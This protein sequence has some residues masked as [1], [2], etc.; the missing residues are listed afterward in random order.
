MAKKRK[1]EDNFDPNDSDFDAGG[2]LD[3]TAD[4][5]D[6]V[7][8]DFID[9]ADF[10][11]ESSVPSDPGEAVILSEIPED[12]GLEDNDEPTPAVEE[13]PEPAPT[14]KGKGIDFSDP[15]SGKEKLDFRQTLDPRS[16]DEYEASQWGDVLGAVISSELAGK[17]LPSD[18]GDQLDKT[19]LS[20]IPDMDSRDQL[21]DGGMSSAFNSS[22]T[23]SSSGVD[24]RASTPSLDGLLNVQTRPVV[25]EIPGLGDVTAGSRLQTLIA[26]RPKG[27]SWDFESPFPILANRVRTDGMV[28][29]H[30]TNLEGPILV[31]VPT[32]GTTDFVK[33]T[34]SESTDL[35]IGY[36]QLTLKSKGTVD[37]AEAH[38]SRLQEKLQAF[39]TATAAEAADPDY[40]IVRELAQGGM[41]VVYLAKQTA[42]SREIA[43]K[44]L[45]PIDPKRKLP[46]D[47]KGKTRRRTTVNKQ[48]QE[49]FLSEA[50]VTANLVHPN[51]VPVHDLGR[52][53]TGDPFYTMKVVEGLPWSKRLEHMTREENIEV[54]LKVCDAMA[55]AHSKGVINR[56]LKPDNVMLG[57]FGEVV[58]LDWG[59]AVHA[60]DV[61]SG[62]PAAG[63]VTTVGAGT[64]LY[65]AP[66][67]ITGPITKIGRH[68]DIYLL[69]GILYEIVTGHP[70]HAPGNSRRAM[71]RSIRN[72]MIR[73]TTVKSELVDIA[74]HAMST[75]PE[76]RFES[77]QAFQEAIR[78]FE[79]HEE[80]LNLSTRARELTEQAKAGEGN[81]EDYQN[82]VALYGESLRTWPGNTQAEE[83]LRATRLEFA[84]VARERGDYDLGLQVARDEQDKEFKTVRAKM[85]KGKKKRSRTKYITA[86]L[87]ASL[88]LGGLGAA[89]TFRSQYNEIVTVRG[90][91]EKI[92]ADAEKIEA[93]AKDTLAEAVEK[94]KEADQKLSDANTA[95]S[96]AET[97]RTEATKTL[98]KAAAKDR[99]ADRKL[100]DANTANSEAETNRTEAK[101][102]RATARREVVESRITVI[103][104]SIE[105]GD[106]DSAI[107][108]I[109]ELLASEEFD[110]LDEQLRKN[111]AKS[112]VA[113]RKQLRDS[114][115]EIQQGIGAA[116]IGT[117]GI[118]AFA[119][120]SELSVRGNKVPEVIDT[121]QIALSP[122]STT[123]AAV[124]RNAITIY[125]PAKNQR[126]QLPAQN[127]AALSFIGPNGLVLGSTTGEIQIRDLNSGEVK[128]ST[129]VAAVKDIVYL[130][131]RQMLLVASSRGGQSIECSAFRIENG[132][133]TITRHSQLNTRNVL[134][135]PIARIVVSPDEKYLAVANSRTG[136][137]VVLTATGSRD[138]FPYRLANNN[139]RFRAHSGPIRD[140]AFSKDSRQLIT[141]SV[142][143]TV[144]VWQRRPTGFERRATLLGHG[145]PIEA[146]GF[147]GSPDKA[148]SIGRD[149]YI[150]RWDIDGE[151]KRRKQLLKVSAAKRTGLRYL[152]TVFGSGSGKV[153]P[154][155]VLQQPTGDSAHQGT[156]VRT[157]K[158]S[159]TRAIT[160]GDNR[161]ATLWDAASGKSLMRPDEEDMPGVRDFEEGHEFNI[162]GLKFFRSNGDLR[163]LTSGFDATV[164]VW[165]ADQDGGIGYQLA[166]LDR[167][168]MQNAATVS[169]DGELIITSG[170][171]YEEQRKQ[172]GDGIPIV[173]AQLWQA[174]DLLAGKREPESI[175]LS[176]RFHRRR[177]TSVAI[178]QDK[179]LAATGALDGGVAI[180]DIANPESARMV[181][182]KSCHGKSPVTGMQFLKNR[183]L[184]TA[185]ADGRVVQWSLG[186]GSIATDQVI[187]KERAQINSMQ[188]TP[189]EE[190]VLFISAR[191]EKKGGQR[192][193]KTREV[194]T[195]Q[196]L[197]TRLHIASLKGS[198]EAGKVNGNGL[199]VGDFARLP[200]NK[201]DF[202][203]ISAAW[204]PGSGSVVAVVTG[205]REKDRPNDRVVLFVNT[206]TGKVLKGLAESE[207]PPVAIA[208]PSDTDGTN[209]MATFDGVNA[210]LWKLQYEGL[211][212]K[213]SDLKRGQI[214]AVFSPH[215]QVFAA[216]LSGDDKYLVTASDAIRVFDSKNQLSLYKS[217]PADNGQI[218]SIAFAPSKEPIYRLLSARR[219]GVVKVWDWE[220][221]QGPDDE[222][223][224]TQQ[225]RLETGNRESSGFQAANPTR[226]AVW[227]PKGNQIGT[228]ILEPK[229]WTKNNNNKWVSKSAVTE[230]GATLLCCAFSAD[231]KWF[232]AGGTDADE[233]SVGWVWNVDRIKNDEGDPHCRISGHRL[234]GITAISFVAK[235][236]NENTPYIATGG[237]DGAVLMWDWWEKRT[238]PDGE[239]HTAFESFRFLTRKDKVTD[240]NERF[241]EAHSATV[242]CIDASVPGKIATSSEDGTAILWS[243]PLAPASDTQSLSL[244]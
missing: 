44:T 2:T 26:L 118:V 141:G 137:L 16:M 127:V 61:R 207:A 74:K 35:G 45:K 234:G 214:E 218:T 238:K 156:P 195:S 27:D 169:E 240:I 90:N 63:E 172:N 153:P 12:E 111:Y 148:I 144:R 149:N 41:G 197:D 99:E 28:I 103:S 128:S 67:M 140:M 164:S 76:D 18:P 34:I 133:T 232:A 194:D 200:L 129:R 9:D 121:R 167:V 104:G 65:M 189:D 68:S 242:T 241:S 147:D 21:V 106:Y 181:A 178:S 79:K 225:Q 237:V 222:G 243:N 187:A 117:G 175:E 4:Q 105:A 83:E 215:S 152:R 24:F 87:L 190:R 96:E 179:Q 15:N 146:C 47:S 217:S 192:R 52:T 236:E 229:V 213:A 230:P 109:D 209:Q 46:K 97:N 198:P 89:A 113:R 110:G 22:M 120:Q 102:L 233:N 228:A 59:L 8:D 143:Q 132:G 212:K 48:Q 91:A 81:Y 78:E 30:S 130:K 100:S 116:S 208:F 93:D 119:T 206:T 168:G 180:W 64:P 107:T 131:S 73:A 204:V 58:V 115:E 38:Y 201:T 33:C 162:G 165:D 138:D 160:T 57:D 155:R 126:V 14:P 151:A 202:E 142:D 219:D 17:T 92:E 171:D 205:C 37:I 136:Q 36:W 114:S 177:I 85:E 199:K 98:A 1:P 157:I 53:T 51:I 174:S 191:S 5:G 77:V 203:L 183:K 55:Y 134:N 13:K 123:V 239:P 161:R 188:V 42:L 216:D 224:L 125:R 23:R 112:L 145:G 39:E 182:S 29:L 193:N 231:G 221:A 54:L 159:G 170:F 235:N 11:A 6:D 139:D 75:D 223:S 50:V 227:G 88:L 122:D 186:G 226:L 56:D 150:R 135:A 196:V 84:D 43:F 20:D 176:S 95:N 60:P 7:L 158:L 211:S 80:S 220:P 82:A 3:P 173:F 94:D 166:Q 62:I 108:R 154:R 49:M 71:E 86:A 69:G 10:F 163:L 185:G 19:R 25:G 101:T 40:E 70:P 184:I 66:E 72:N 32:G 31:E 124:G 210:Y 244:P